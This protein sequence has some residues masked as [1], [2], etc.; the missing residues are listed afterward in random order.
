MA[1]I[2]VNSKS[3]VFLTKS[4]K[5]ESFEERRDDFLEE[6]LLID[7]YMK[8]EQEQDLLK[9]HL[10]IVLSR[11]KY[12]GNSSGYR[13]SALSERKKILKEVIK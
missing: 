6:I 9:K 13:K 3:Q 10:G 4:Y 7:E 8:L 11:L 12:S 1:G 2:S 5:N